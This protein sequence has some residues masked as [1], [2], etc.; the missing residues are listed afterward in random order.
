MSMESIRDRI[1]NIIEKQLPK[2]DNAIIDVR[3]TSLGN[4]VGPVNIEKQGPYCSRGYDYVYVLL[5]IALNTDNQLI[6]DSCLELKEYDLKNG[7]YSILSRIEEL[8]HALERPCYDNMPMEVAAWHEEKWMEWIESEE[9]KCL[10]DELKSLQKKRDH[11][12]SEY[13]SNNK[14]LKQIIEIALNEIRQ[15]MAENEKEIKRLILNEEKRKKEAAEKSAKEEAKRPKVVPEGFDRPLSE[16]PARAD[17]PRVRVSPPFRKVY[18]PEDVEKMKN[19]SKKEAME[20]KQNLILQGKYTKVFVE[21]HEANKA[22]IRPEVV[23]EGFDKPSSDIPARAD[24]PRI[25]A[26]VNKKDKGFSIMKLLDK[27][28]RFIKIFKWV[29]LGD[30]YLKKTHLMKKYTI[31]VQDKDLPRYADG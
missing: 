12:V 10:S 22:V 7:W 26:V 29:L 24:D 5:H 1:L 16:I 14:V 2:I 11:L 8:E 6:K 23:P 15:V 25:K 30:S 27:I 28:I 19:M 20:Y 4:S 31:A 13:E 3:Y 21:D 9:A 18:A 17:D